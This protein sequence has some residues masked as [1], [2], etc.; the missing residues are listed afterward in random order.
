VNEQGQHESD[1]GDQQEY[2]DRRPMQTHLEIEAKYDVA[3]GQQLPDLIGVGGITATV[4]QP[5]MVLT[6]T[7]FD[8]ADHALVA[9][10]ATL[11]RRTGGT[12]DGWHL[13]LPLADGERLEVH[14]PLGRG[15]TPPAALTA[16]VR[17]FVRTDRLEAI[18]T[19][20]NRRTVH[21]LMDGGGGVLAELADDSVTGERHAA[22][23][24]LVTWRELEIELVEGDREVLAALDAAVQAAGVQ[25]A[26]SASK[27]GRVLG[28]PPVR[29]AQRPAFRRK[30][31]VGEVLAVGLQH[32]VLDLQAADPLVRLD[33][34]DAPTRM[35]AAV[36]Q[37]RAALA[38]QRQVVADEL[39]TSIR[40][41]LAW[42]DSVVAVLDEV[43]TTHAAIRAA[44]AVQPRELVIGPVNR[45]VDRERSA[46]RRAAV[47]VVR[48]AMD[49]S[50]Y[51]DLLGRVVELP[52]RLPTQPAAATRATDVLPDLA[53]RALRRAERRLGQLARA[54]SDDERRRQQRGARRAVHRAVYAERLHS[55]RASQIQG[56]LES[57]LDEA[58]AVLARLEVSLS[59]QEVLRD[60]AMQAYAAGENAFTFGLLHGLEQGRADN[61]VRETT[62]L[63]KHLRQL[64]RL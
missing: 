8:T 23:G 52:S 29:F 18:A 58:A 64:D 43:D 49:S 7:Y 30:T 4:A 5:E 39:T 26:S 24:E 11:R 14:R 27:L 47:T 13:K 37:L 9:A 10:R 59:T 40:V 25:P 35:R 21:Q 36:Q 19:L 16:L 32:A 15:Q 1:D 50:R 56:P 53:D 63:R 34:P 31:P 45:R 55:G 44:L 42:L 17:G 3:D 33:R 46:A 57:T 60:L 28:S 54:P 51:L 41:E 6:A 20:V 62:K 22:E 12:D 48:D 61:L 2:P 38:L